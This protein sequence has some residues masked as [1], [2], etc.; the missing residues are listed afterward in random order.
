LCIDLGITCGTRPIF[1]PKVVD[2]PVEKDSELALDGTVYLGYTCV[3]EIFL[4]SKV[5]A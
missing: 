3:K 5:V 2:M 4:N 1:I